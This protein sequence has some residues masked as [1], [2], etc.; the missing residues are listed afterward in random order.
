[1]SHSAEIE[2][3]A[4]ISEEEMHVGWPLAST[5]ATVATVTLCLFCFCFSDG[6]Q[7]QTP[8]GDGQ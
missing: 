7:G 2:G 6:A 3:V 5:H 4:Q 8:G 1:M